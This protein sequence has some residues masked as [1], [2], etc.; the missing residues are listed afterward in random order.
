MSLT[1]GISKASGGAKYSNYANWIRGA[2]DD[3]EI[4]NLIESEDL[5]S[6]MARID[7]LLLTGGPDIEPGRYQHPEAVEKCEVMDIPR[8]EAEFRML[9]LAEERELPVLGV[10]RGLQVVNVYYGG[11]LIPHLPD[12]LSGSYAHS[13]D[14]EVD[15]RHAVEVT[16]GSLLFKATEELEGEVNSAHHQAPGEIAPGMIATAKATDGVIEALEWSDSAR[17]PYML[18]VQWHP[19]RMV[20]T[21]SPFARG[22]LEQFIFEARSARILAGVRKAEPR[23][24]PNEPPE[25]EPPQGNPLLPI[26]Q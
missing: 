15:R 20:D 26:V 18:S 13:K 17:R 10:C 9:E 21:D 1:I 12:I 22:I 3:I 5:E 23:E 11:T 25:F 8:D 14:G 19:E 2:G 6:D 24:R 7:A 16:P 4:I